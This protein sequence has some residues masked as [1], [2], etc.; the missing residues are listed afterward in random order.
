M[1]NNKL[2]M[3]PLADA[4][5]KVMEADE[6]KK[7]ADT[8]HVPPPKSVPKHDPY[9]KNPYEVDNMSDRQLR[10]REMGESKVD[11]MK[12]RLAAAKE[13]KADSYEFGKDKKSEAKPRAVAGSSYGG[14][15]QKDIEE[16]KVDDMKD[17]LAA[18]KEKKADSY[19]F[20]KDKK[21]EAKP[22]AV[23]GSSYGGSKQKDVEES[24]ASRLIAR[25]KE[26][27][28][29]KSSGTEPTFTDN[30][31]GE[32]ISRSAKA[33]DY[34]DDFVHSKNPKF[35]NKSKKERINMALGAYYGK[36]NEEYISEEIYNFNIDPT[37]GQMKDDVELLV[38][39]YDRKLKGKEVIMIEEESDCVTPPQAK[40]IA[41]KEVDKHEKKMHDKKADLVKKEEVEE[42]DELSK[43]TL[44]SY[45]DKAKDR[46]VKHASST[47]TS[48]HV[49]NVKSVKYA[50]NMLK[51]KEK[52]GKFSEEVEQIDELSKKTL[53][54]YMSKAVDSDLGMPK[55]SKNP[56]ARMKGIGAA[57]KKLLQEPQ[58][59]VHESNDHHTHAAHYEDP[60]TGEWTGMSLL[61]AKSDEDAIHQAHK[62]CKAGCRLSKVERH[63]AVKEDVEHIKEK[64]GKKETIDTL[65][66]REG[67]VPLEA[68]ISNAHT[69]H[70]VELKSED[71]GPDGSEGWKD[72]PKANKDK[73]GAVHSPM[74]R[75]KHLAKQ[76]MKKINKDH[77]MKNETMMGKI[78][79]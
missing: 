60:K 57:H 39:G 71:I 67:K 59:S 36:K 12:D 64:L 51:A 9:K 23:S 7:V 56:E 33:G 73:S 13:K 50:K 58:K 54:S 55:H 75:V 66:G 10:R 41:D 4:V 65:K 8:K 5:R 74:S 21:S 17:R 37:T 14:S 49:A 18:A 16:S 30:N 28:E 48:D 63:I 44:N 68:K 70:K 19:E 6:V 15:K 11:D 45:M 46:Y 26:I 25:A 47:S 78:S 1:F 62:M 35:A 38:S 24:F 69:S 53:K 31:M 42:L 20:G 76:A 72:K 61:S 40:N 29:A 22:R 32:T 79:N 27:N 3:N 34:I 77:G 52:G 2:K 43:G